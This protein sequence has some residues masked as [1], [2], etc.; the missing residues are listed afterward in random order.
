[1]ID[2]NE[3]KNTI[4]NEYQEVVGCDD[5]CFLVKTDKLK[6]MKFNE[7]ISNFHLYAFDL[8]IRFQ[9]LGYKNYVI[10]LLTKHNSSRKALD[11]WNKSIQNFTSLYGKEKI[12]KL[13]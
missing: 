2:T 4:K 11:K 7:R 13:F 1:M 5:F 3:Y 8:S 10:N 6:F 12:K 9:E